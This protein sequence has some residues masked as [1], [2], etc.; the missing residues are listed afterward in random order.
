MGAVWARVRADVRRRWPAWIA[1]A[2]T[3]GLAGA[4][5]L[6]AAAGARRTDTAYGRF[7]AQGNAED[8][9]FS[10]GPPSDPAVRR[11]LAEIE[12]LPEVEVVGHVAAANVYGLEMPDTIPYQYAAV[13]ARYGREIDR[14]NVVEGRRPRPGRADEVLVNRAMARRLDLEVGDIARWLAF[15]PEEIEVEAPDLSDATRVRLRVV[16]IG[17]YPNEV[18]PTAQYDAVPFA[19]LTPAFFRAHADETQDYSFA[20]VRL[21]NGN[22]DLPA[23]RQGM[24]RVLREHGVDQDSGFFAD[25]SD[26]Y[27]Q[28]RRAIRPQALALAVFAAL[29]AAA[30]VMVIVQVLARQVFL[31]ADEHRALGALGM[32]KG[33]LFATTMARIVTV[34]L[35]GGVIALIGAVLA[36]PL[37]PI[38]PARLAEPNPGFAVNVAILGLGVLVLLGLV[39]GLAAIPAWRAAATAGAARPSRGRNPS[40]AARAL[41]TA[42]APVTSTLGVRGALQP[43]VGRAQVPV[44]STIIVSGLAIALVV[45]TASF[46]AN[47]DRLA[48]TP[49]LYGWDWTF[50]AGNGFFPVEVKPT[51]AALEEVPGVRAVAAANYANVTIAGRPVGA[52]GIDTL[53]GDEVF[54]T[55][56]EGR[57]PVRADEIVLGTRT[58][59]RADRGVGETVEVVVNGEARRMRIV[60]RAIF[61]KLGAGS[62]SPTNLGYG[63]ATITDAIVDPSAPAG[64]KYSVVLLA[65]RPGSDPVASQAA[66]NRALRPQ[67]L[68]GGEVRC[69]EVADRP[70][71]VSNYTRIR[72]TSLVLVAVLALVALGLLVHV[73]ISSVRRRR[74]DLALYKTLGFLRRQVSAVSAWQATT[75]AAIALLIGI[76][77]G[78]ALGT[79]AW[80]VFADQLGVAPDSEF[81]PALL[82]AIPGVLLLANVVATVPALLAARTHP[83]T[84]LRSE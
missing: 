39:V 15:E 17:V 20:V 36:S 71:D 74:R 51:L 78:I 75:M 45:A 60:G 48:T 29:T 34:A 18:V 56:L 13:D 35:A 69:V 59:R 46:T 68:C 22:A 25:R 32:T 79:F 38:G 3:I 65:M 57:V 2:L 76:P 61:P 63:A 12:R 58:L 7:L 84:V 64:E 81:P 9:Y 11:M 23:F 8:V 50:K 41:A 21:R 40:R 70:G 14:P 55:L 10:I 26:S 67:V 80:R 28:V 30:F 16:G 66:L 4:V 62:F 82:L 33:Q 31:A 47:L 53:R 72:G 1:L 24:D 49:K 77:V 19:Y 73:L 42:G 44:R 27:E 83:A 37:M 52:V 43:G 6:T 54:P 5:V